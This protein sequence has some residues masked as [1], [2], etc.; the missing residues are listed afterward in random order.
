MNIQEFVADPQK[1]SQITH[2]DVDDI[3]C[4]IIE[5]L[6]KKIMFNAV[7]VANEISSGNIEMPKAAFRKQA[8]D[9]IVNAIH[10]YLTHEKWKVNT[11]ILPYLITSI[12]RLALSVIDNSKGKSSRV[13]STICPACKE[14]RDIEELT[15]ENGVYICAKCEK[16]KA[17]LEQN[18]QTCSEPDEIEAIKN[19]IAL[20]TAFYRHSPTG[21]RC[22]KCSK[23]VPNSSKINDVLLCPYY[24]CNTDC[25]NAE[26]MRH[27]IS[28]LKRTHLSMNIMIGG[29]K[30]IF[31]T[32][33]DGSSRELIERYCTGDDNAFFLLSKE[34]EYSKKFDIVSKIIW[35]QK[36]INGTLRKLPIKLAMYEAFES[37]LSEFPVEMMDYLTVGGQGG[38]AVQ[39]LIFQ[40]FAEIMQNKL[41]ISIFSKG[42]HIYIDSPMDER[43]SLYKDLRQF[44]NYI[45]QNLCIKRR[46][47]YI[48]KDDELIENKDKHFIGKIISIKTGND[49]DLMPYI[50]SYNFS[51]IHMTND[52][53]IVS[54]MDVVVKYYSIIPSYTIG[55]MVH[56]QRIKKKLADSINKRLEI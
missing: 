18:L 46:A 31:N 38:V 36:Q 53:E 6:D 8:E 45:N 51:T 37:V 56:L 15:V 19:K 25:S 52:L 54:G 27:P 55:S 35:G 34:Q 21:V 41:P 29:Q 24:G 1:F 33:S 23:F 22:P 32:M 14:M 49:I 43:L 39:P 17:M 2:D 3:S 47:Q 44:T 12:N 9:T 48:I 26:I 13:V 5:L 11:P 28:L 20:L 30:S 10:T 42:M 4:L 50:D 7:K 16:S 40:K